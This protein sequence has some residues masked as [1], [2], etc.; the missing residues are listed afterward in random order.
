MKKLNDLLERNEILKEASKKRELLADLKVGR[1]ALVDKCSKYLPRREAESLDNYKLRVENAELFNMLQKN[2]RTFTS[3]PF[4]KDMQILSDDLYKEEIFKLVY[5]IDGSE[6]TATDFFKSCLNEALWFSQCHTFIDYNDDDN[7][8]SM[9][10]LD[11]EN[12]I[13]FDFKNNDLIY[14]RFLM[15]EKER[16]G[17]KS[18]YRKVVYEYWKDLETDSVFWNDYV[19]DLSDDITINQSAKFKE[20]NKNVKYGLKYIPLVSFYPMSTVNKFNPD[21]IFENVAELQLSYFRTNSRMKD[22]ESVVTVPILN[23]KG[24]NID[25]NSS[26]EKKLVM[27][28]KTV[29]VFDS[30][31]AEMS[32]LSPPQESLSS[33]RTNL[34]ES[35]RQINTLLDDLLNGRSGS[36]TATEIATNASSNN[37]FLSSVVISLVK[38][39]EK[40]IDTI[41]LWDNFK[42]LTYTVVLTTDYSITLD[43]NEVN[44]LLQMRTL[45]VISDETLFDEAKRRG[46]LDDEWTY[47]KE[48]ERLLNQVSTPIE[49][50]NGF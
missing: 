28:S 39:I 35:E 4:K 49:N 37:N 2:I 40:N 11:F 34:L 47:A 44:L 3:K 46:A 8:H 18:L 50:F 24:V 7:V 15:I 29:N 22:V 41:L 13:D 6:T 45:N 17:F 16:K 38:F 30:E 33:L 26:E 27:D 43:Q 12:I 5:N 25:Q 20:R 31:S 23:I 14:F 10:I 1:Q 48:K 32:W 36:V 9:M 42:D 19:S 21:L